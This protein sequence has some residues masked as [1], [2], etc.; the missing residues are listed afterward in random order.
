M[1]YNFRFGLGMKTKTLSPLS[2]DFHCVGN[3]ARIISNR[4]I[5]ELLVPNTQ[6]G[7]INSD[8]DRSI[9]CAALLEC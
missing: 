1:H 6:S 2:F 5:P 7:R 9:L 4:A 3:D 8:I